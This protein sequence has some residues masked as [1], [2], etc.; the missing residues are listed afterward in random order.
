MLMVQR[1]RRGVGLSVVMR[2]CDGVVLRAACGQLQQQLDASIVEAKA[3]VLG[4]RLAVQAGYTHVTLESD[5]LKLIKMLQCSTNE[6]S[7]L[8]VFVRE[9]LL[10]ARSF[11]SVNFVYVHR[12][13]NEVAH[14]MAHLNPIVYT[15]RVWDG[16][17]PSEL[18]DAIASDFI[19]Q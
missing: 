8:G 11:E 5:C 4:L 19:Y 18:E 2:D 15:T 13:A 12:D 9:T 14:K 3:C 6:G 1:M 16:G 7:Y 10:V 17:Y